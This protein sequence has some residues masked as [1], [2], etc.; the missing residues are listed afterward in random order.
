M[1]NRHRR[2]T[3]QYYYNQHKQSAKRRGIAWEFTYE[4]WWKVWE[5]SGKWE[6]RGCKAGQYCMRRKDDVGPYSPDNV[7]IGS[8]VDNNRDGMLKWRTE[9]REEKLQKE[10][11]KISQII[12]QPVAVHKKIEPKPTPKEIFENKKLNAWSWRQ[13]MRDT[14]PLLTRVLRV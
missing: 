1:G 4:T 8:V 7:F 12:T 10:K 14:F 9:Q 6:Q 2:K 5:D 3:P 11:L 13:I